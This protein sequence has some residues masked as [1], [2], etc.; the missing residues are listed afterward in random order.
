MESPRFRFWSRFLLRLTVWGGTFVVVVA[1]Y[2]LNLCF[3]SVPEPSEYWPEKWVSVQSLKPEVRGW[4]E[5]QYI[6]PC[7]FAV[8]AVRQVDYRKYL[9]LMVVSL[10]T[11]ERPVMVDLFAAQTRLSSFE[12]PQ[13]VRLEDLLLSMPSAGDR[14]WVLQKLLR[15]GAI[16]PLRYRALRQRYIVLVWTDEE[17]SAALQLAGYGHDR[18]ANSSPES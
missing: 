8:R 12:H 10:A 16:I 15:D 17:R 13:D 6:H 14:Q 9:P 3:Q 5:A 4:V 7:A 1:G 18:V 2:I 11:L